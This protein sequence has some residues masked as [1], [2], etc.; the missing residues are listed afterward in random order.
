LKPPK[1]LKNAQTPTSRVHA[2]LDG[3]IFMSS[4]LPYE[5]LTQISFRNNSFLTCRKIENLLQIAQSPN[6]SGNRYI[7][8][9]R[10]E[11]Y[12]NR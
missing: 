3:G 1:L 11:A 2:V 5:D 10:I 12:D 8:L 4:T 7:A 9:N 6:L